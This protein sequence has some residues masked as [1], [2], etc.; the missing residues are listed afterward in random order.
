MSALL[1]SLSLP[2]A[3]VVGW[4]DGGNTGLSLALHHPEQVR[5]LSVMGANLYANST[6]L[7][8]KFLQQ[9]R[10]DKKKLTLVWP[11]KADFRKSRRLVNIL[12]K[13]P[14][15]TTQELQQIK[16]PT[17]VLAGEKD[18]IK[19]P[20]TRLIAANI[21]G[22]QLV[23]FPGLSHYAQQENPALFNETVLKFLLAPEGKQ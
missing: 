23:I 1:K 6:V 18:I 4:S 10:H 16:A 8:E 21:P 20:H 12:L 15:M 22:S 13:Y 9:I 5:R 14:R 2:A 19:E 3:D 11:L 17:L 7:P